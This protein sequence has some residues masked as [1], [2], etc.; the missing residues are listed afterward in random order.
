LLQH[1]NGSVKTLVEGRKDLLGQTAKR[2]A[3]TGGN[4]IAEQA[5]SVAV[6]EKDGEGETAQPREKEGAVAP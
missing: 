5:A 1:K 2:I 6:K 3:V 4:G